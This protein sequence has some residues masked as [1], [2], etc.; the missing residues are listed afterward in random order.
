MSDPDK[1]KVKESANNGLFKYILKKGSDKKEI[2]LYLIKQ[3]K[4]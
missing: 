1:L 3:D 2:I 4:V